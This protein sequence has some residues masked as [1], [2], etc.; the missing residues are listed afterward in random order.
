MATDMSLPQPQGMAPIGDHPRVPTAAEEGEPVHT[1]QPLARLSNPGQQKPVLPDLEKMKGV[2]A[3]LIKK[4]EDHGPLKAGVAGF[5]ALGTPLWA[6]LISPVG[7][8]LAG[9]AVTFI[10][11]KGAGAV[12]VFFGVGAMIASIALMAVFKAAAFVLVVGLLTTPIGWGFLAAAAAIFVIALCVSAYK[13]H[14]QSQAIENLEGEL[15]KGIEALKQQNPEDENIK[16]LEDVLAF[17]PEKCDKIDSWARRVSGLLDNP[18]ARLYEDHGKKL[19]QDYEN[20]S[21]KLNRIKE[22]NN[23][24]DFFKRIQL[25]SEGAQLMKD[26]ETIMGKWRFFGSD[27][28]RPGAEP[29]E[30]IR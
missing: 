1:S 13:S 6:A 8:L 20:L 5:A 2:A 15:K 23:E 9:F 28:S 21:A 18:Q 24:E 3:E 26:C 22:I 25:A 10:K 29:W 7:L 30:G 12:A 4:R 16:K 11:P 27:T 19:K 17:T 14:K